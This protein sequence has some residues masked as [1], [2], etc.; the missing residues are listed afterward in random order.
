MVDELS[1]KYARFV[2]ELDNGS[3]LA[4]PDA[5]VWDG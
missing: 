2:F 4:F 1:L 3:E 5:E